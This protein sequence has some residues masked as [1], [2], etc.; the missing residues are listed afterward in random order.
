LK[1][2]TDYP[3]LNLP[4]CR[5][6]V[7][8]HG[9]ELC[10]W[11]YA[12]AGATA[13]R[14]SARRGRWLVLTPEEWVRRHVLAM[15]TGRAGISATSIVQEH[16]V[17]VNGTT[18]RADIVVFGTGGRPVLLVECKAP[19][20]AIDDATLSQAFRYNAVLGARN[21]MLTNGLDHYI[22]E[23]SPDGEYLPLK[24]FPELE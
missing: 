14:G 12:R 4:P 19:G 17:N 10:V 24:E 3:K 2:R 9:G 1:T 23:V 21:V 15:L 6:K 16:P 20:V 13:G 5:L 7:A 8:E 11:D 22:Y 18:Q